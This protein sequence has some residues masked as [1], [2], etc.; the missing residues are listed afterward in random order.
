MNLIHKNPFHIIS[1]LAD[2]SERLVLKLWNTFIL[3]HFIT[4]NIQTKNTYHIMISKVHNS[5]SVFS[6]QTVY[7]N[8]L[9]WQK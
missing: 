3:T 9:I 1:V 5:L 4:K 6:I 2:P 7:K 8:K